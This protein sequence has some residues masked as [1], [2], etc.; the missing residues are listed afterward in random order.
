M[1]TLDYYQPTE[2][3]QRLI[4]ALRSGY[5]EQGTGC[6]QANGK[7]C[8]LGVACRVSKVELPIIEG[9]VVIMFGEEE[10][11]S[12]LPKVVQEELGWSIEGGETYIE[13]KCGWRNSLDELNDNGFSFNQIADIIE[14][15]LVRRTDDLVDA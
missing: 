9:G 5:Y 10:T 11:Q 6:L 12:L 13:G 8:C 2:A 15:G 4:D 7:L 1:P 14:A 3:E